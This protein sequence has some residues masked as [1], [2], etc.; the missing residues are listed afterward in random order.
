MSTEV[1][2]CRC[3]LQREVGSSDRQHREGE[4][5]EKA[6]DDRFE[7]EVADHGGHEFGDVREGVA[8]PEAMRKVE[9]PVAVFGGLEMQG[10]R[11]ETLPLG[12]PDDVGLLDLR[13][14]AREASRA[15]QVRD[16]VEGLSPRTV[17]LRAEAL[18]LAV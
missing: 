2:V 11:E 9:R 18:P 16:E 15:R 4:Y 1:R 13:D 17:E 5:A 10:N 3:K 8:R 14:D 6:E 7:T 12:P